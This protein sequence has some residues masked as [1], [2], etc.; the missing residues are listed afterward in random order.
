MTKPSEVN[1]E[2]AVLSAATDIP[3]EEMLEHISEIVGD[4]TLQH[5]GDHT[6]LSAFLRVYSVGFE[7]GRRYAT[8]V[9]ERAA[10]RV[11]DERKG[12]RSA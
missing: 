11:S 6:L 12:Q 5:E 4:L 7:H 10:Q 9:W 2:A 1:L 3:S 8:E